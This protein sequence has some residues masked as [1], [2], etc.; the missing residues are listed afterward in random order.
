M[1][2]ISIVCSVFDLNVHDVSVFT[3]LPFS[4]DE[5]EYCHVYV[6]DFS[7][8]FGLNDWIYGTYTLNS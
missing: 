7:T 1:S 8:G 2:D 6:C 3:L 5:W 4:S